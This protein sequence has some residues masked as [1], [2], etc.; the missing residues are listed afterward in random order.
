MP[1]RPRVLAAVGPIAQAHQRLWIGH[2]QISQQHRIDKREDGRI[3]ANTQGECKHCRKRK[4]RRFA[5]LAQAVANILQE[6]FEPESAT[7]LTAAFLNLIDASELQSYKTAGFVF[8]SAG[9]NL[10]GDVC[11]K[12]KRSSLSSSLSNSFGKIATKASSW[13]PSSVPL[14]MRQP[15]RVSRFQFSVSSLR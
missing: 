2:W 7:A 10:V 8:G 3:R 15:H 11:F 12:W 6:R 9:A 4:A 14:R 13:I 5:K 1:I